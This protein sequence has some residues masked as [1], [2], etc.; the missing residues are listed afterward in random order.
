MRM[1]VCYLD[2]HEAGLCCCLVIQKTYYIHYSCLTSFVMYL[3]TLPRTYSRWLTNDEL[4]RT[5]KDAVV[6]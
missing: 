4:E 6:V 3:L 1:R 2:C 5:R